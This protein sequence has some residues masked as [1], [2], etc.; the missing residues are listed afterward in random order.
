MPIRSLPIG[1]GGESM[2]RVVHDDVSEPKPIAMVPMHH[3]DIINA[4][5][6]TQ[7]YTVSIPEVW[8]RLIRIDALSEDDAIA[9]VYKGIQS[10]A[11]ECAGTD[12]LE[13]GYDMDRSYWSATPATS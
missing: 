3:D 11:I 13:F 7:H 9:T 6:T 12:D 2:S 5:R 1:G 10:G 4:V 8:N